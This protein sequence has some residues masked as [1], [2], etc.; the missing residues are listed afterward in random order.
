MR[1]LKSRWTL[2]AL[3]TVMTVGLW[4]RPAQAYTTSTCIGGDLYIDF[5]DDSGGYHGFIRY[6]H[7]AGCS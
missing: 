7:Y 6:R 2:V 1:R 3:L 5:Y 4:V